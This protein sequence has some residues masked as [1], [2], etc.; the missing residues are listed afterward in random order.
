M[1]EP[2]PETAPLASSLGHALGRPIVELERIVGGRNSR[3]YRA[4]DVEGTRYAVKLYVRRPGR[5]DALAAEYTALS[6]LRANGIAA[7]PRPIAWDAEAGWG[8]Y[9]YVEGA[10]V[11]GSDVSEEDIA[12]AV[13]F[14]AALRSLGSAAGARD[15]APAAEACFAVRPIL[16]GIEERLARLRTAAAAEPGPLVGFLAEAFSP[17]LARVVRGTERRLARSGRAADSVLPERL[18][19]LSPSDFGF[20]NALRRADGSLAFVDFEYFGWDDPAK[21]IA[22]FLL[23]PG[24]DLAEPLR[25]AFAKRVAAA[26]HDDDDLGERVETVYPLFGLKWCLILLNE[27]L[28]ADLRRRRFAGASGVDPAER[29]AIQLAKARHMLE[30]VI[31]EHERFPYRF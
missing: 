14:L 28:G 22:D 19:T 20:H 1:R 3:V 27:F 11:L 13:N 5:R 15:L 18:R 16:E 8:A 26:F 24:M 17:A 2:D 4:R 25:A 10:V 6:F 29:R 31:E 23:H 9:E 7:V 12:S 21:M 30:K